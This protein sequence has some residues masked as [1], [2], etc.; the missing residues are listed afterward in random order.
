[1]KFNITFLLLSCFYF[2]SA[3][4]PYELDWKKESIY[5]GLGAGFYT[6]AGLVESN[7][8]RPLTDLEIL[9]LDRANINS[10]D[11]NATFNFSYQ[12]KKGSDYLKY[13]SYAFPFLFLSNKKTRGDF[14]KIMALYGETILIVGGLTSL[15]KRVALRPRPLVYNEL[16]PFS[17]KQQNNSRY[18]FFSGHASVSAA[19]SIF[20]A[21][22]FS[23]YFPESKWKPVVWSAAILIP[24]STAYLRVK[25]GKHY[26]TDV[27]TGAAIGG[28]IGFLIPHLHRKKN[29]KGLSVTP[30]FS[31]FYLSKTF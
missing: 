22:V 5:L 7:S 16:V 4:S 1:M 19:N 11:R 17:D 27:I 3:Q 15:T 23:D 14:G 18:A 29:W 21:K 24:T 30:T 25:A 8:V 6:A 31:G 12:A 10:F 20:A 13:P 28:A 26:P 9:S 2:S